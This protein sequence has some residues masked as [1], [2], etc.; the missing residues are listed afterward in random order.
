MNDFWF[1]TMK[2]ITYAHVES[3]DVDGVPYDRKALMPVA[4]A[5]KSAG[6]SGSPKQSQDAAYREPNRV[7]ANQFR[8][9]GIFDVADQGRGTAP[10]TE[11]VTVGDKGVGGNVAPLRPEVKAA[12]LRETRLLPQTDS[13][14]LVTREQM[15][16]S[17]SQISDRH[18]D[19][20][21]ADNI[22]RALEGLP[23]E[24]NEKH[25]AQ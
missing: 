8:S 10:S 4:T 25:E 20:R 24:R 2:A 19:D 16:P 12:C 11:S 15:A 21:F 3:L 18:G 13:E 23:Q 1:D 17:D 9:A 5:E 14:S 22:L 6:E 7:P